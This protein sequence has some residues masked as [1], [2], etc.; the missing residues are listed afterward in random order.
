[1]EKRTNIEN[2]GKTPGV[3]PPEDPLVTRKKEIQKARD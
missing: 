3:D 2:T 1:M